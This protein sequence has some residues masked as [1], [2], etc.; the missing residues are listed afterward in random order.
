M[1]SYCKL[2][3]PLQGTLSNSWSSSHNL[4]KICVWLRI[5]WSRYEW[6]VQFFECT[7]DSGPWNDV[8]ESSFLMVS[9]LKSRWCSIIRCFKYT[10]IPSVMEYE[11]TMFIMF[12]NKSNKRQCKSSSGTRSPNIKGMFVIKHS[13]CDAFNPNPCPPQSRLIFVGLFSFP[14]SHNQKHTSCSTSFL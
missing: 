13:V 2:V 7:S 8:L 5:S 10:V 11:N 4:W 3:F 1:I 6:V 9:S 12:S 14:D